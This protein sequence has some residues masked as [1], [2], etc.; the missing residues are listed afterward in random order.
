LIFWYAHIRG[1]SWRNSKLVTFWGLLKIQLWSNL[2]PAKK[3]LP[4]LVFLFIFQGFGKPIRKWNIR[5]SENCWG[6]EARSPNIV[7]PICYLPLGDRFCWK[8]CSLSKLRCL[9]HEGT[10]KLFDVIKLYYRWKWECLNMFPVGNYFSWD[11]FRKFKP[12]PLF[13]GYCLFVKP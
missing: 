13:Q 7:F 9:C 6:L 3:V 8:A 11:V 1:K 2:D 4:D 12:F 5:T 10:H